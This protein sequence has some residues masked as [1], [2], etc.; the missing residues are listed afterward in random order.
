LTLTFSKEEEKE[1]TTIK[2]EKKLLM[3]KVKGKPDSL[4]DK[5]N[6]ASIKDMKEHLYI[7][8]AFFEQFKDIYVNPDESKQIYA[9]PKPNALME[10]DLGHYKTFTYIAKELR[11]TSQV[12]K[13]EL[14][15]YG[16]QLAENYLNQV[17]FKF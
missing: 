5:I 1:K 11:E 10:K 13:D 7:P 9:V 12:N 16:D 15:K 14:K 6:K 2:E 8:A 17:F 4:N 3:E